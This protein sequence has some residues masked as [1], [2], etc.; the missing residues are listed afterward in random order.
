MRGAGRDAVRIGRRYLGPLARPGGLVVRIADA[1]VAVR[2]L[3]APRWGNGR[4][5]RG[6]RQ[7]GSG[8]ALPPSLALERSLAA[9][10]AAR[11][12]L[13]VDFGGPCG[14]DGRGCQVS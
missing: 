6:C 2:A 11:T 7:A 10:V 4:E 5:L 12:E 14:W 3:V 13:D 1:T 9:G 8:A